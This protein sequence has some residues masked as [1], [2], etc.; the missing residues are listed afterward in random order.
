M[1]MELNYLGWIDR[2]MLASDHLERLD[3]EKRRFGANG[4]HVLGFVYVDH[5][6]GISM[7]IESFC[8]LDP[9]GTKHMTGGPPQHNSVFLLRY[10]MLRDMDPVVPLADDERRRL[11]LPKHPKWLSGY[12]YEGAEPLRRLSLLH[13]LR[14]EG[15][16]DD[17]KFGLLGD[18]EHRG[19][20]IWGRLE[21]SLGGDYFECELLNEPMQDFG[22]HIRDRVLVR[23]KEVSEGVS[24]VCLGP[25]SKFIE[26]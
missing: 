12:H 18:S 17:I 9:D 20:V 15:Y 8:S 10:D 6:H 7:Q 4:T 24:S 16:P 25:L 13:P 2:W 22:F 14:A 23:V 26:K 3:S 21:N 5:T 1:N 11:K 19:E